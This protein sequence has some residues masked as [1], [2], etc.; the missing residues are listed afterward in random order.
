[1]H[2]VAFAKLGLPHKYLIAEKNNIEEYQAVLNGPTFGG[3][4]IAR[5]FKVD[6]IRYLRKLSKHAHAIGAVNTIIS[7]P[8]GPVGENTDWKA[9][10]TCIL[11]GLSPENAITS[12]TMA[13]IIGAGG[14]ARAAIYALNHLGVTKIGIANR[15]RANAEQLVREMSMLDPGLSLVV[16]DS[17][18]PA[19]LVQNRFQPRIVINAT[20]LPRDGEIRPASIAPTSELLT[21][22]GGGVLLD[23]IFQ[24]DVSRSSLLDLSRR[25][26]N[27]AWVFVPGIEVLLEQGFEQFR[28]WTGRRPPKSAMREAVL[29]EMKD[30]KLYIGNKASLM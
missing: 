23:L 3:A 7:T 21:L 13:L 20:P 19:V 24:G 29:K 8:T 1:M 4:S 9:I 25:P 2:N 6:I 22:Q 10:R 27:M 11:R 12:S 30:N 5:P 15:T 28:L 14:V 18:E 26:E 16:L 17:I